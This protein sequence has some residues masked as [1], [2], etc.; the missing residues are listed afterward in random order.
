MDELERSR[1]V[2]L[3]DRI[4]YLRSI[5]VTATLPPVV[6]RAIAAEL[7]VRDFARGDALMREGEPIVAMHLLTEGSLSLSK[8][9]QT[10]G[11]LAPPQS[12]GFL[13]ILAGGDGT[14]DAVAAEPTRSL[15]LASDALLELM[16]DYFLLLSSTVRYLAERMYQE[17]RDLPA[18]ALGF[19][20]PDVPDLGDREIDLVERIVF[21]RRIT[22]LR[23]TN[24]NALAVMAQQ[25]T[26]VRYAEG[27]VAWR[28]GDPSGQ[29]LFLVSG[30]VKCTTEDGR[31]FRYGPET[32]VGGIE[33]LAQ[34]PRWYEV[35]TETP[36]VAFVG[37]GDALL[38]LFEDN[39]SMAMD[40]VRTLADGLTKLV[41]RKAAMGER[42]LE[43]KRSVSKLGSVPV[44]A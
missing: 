16:E 7:R 21:L 41:A 42:P 35:E 27:T 13:G 36:V 18:E 6:L 33:S 44:G 4:L 19:P 28:P 12:L 29:A 15:E 39:F 32:V 26:P 14:Y 34:A 22:T 38:D 23:K 31:V 8:G 25:V 17:M 2:D 10:I 20:F 24:I 43:V 3:T 9:G 40:F 1:P 37:S 30:T 5:P 11:S